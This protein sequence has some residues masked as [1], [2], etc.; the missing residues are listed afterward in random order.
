M[1]LKARLPPSQQML[2]ALFT[3]WSGNAMFTPS[4]AG[5]LLN[6]AGNG[7]PD[8]KNEIVVVA[9]SYVQ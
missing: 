9:H 2:A 3:N 6:G 7:H 4:A 1:A 8:E 5:T